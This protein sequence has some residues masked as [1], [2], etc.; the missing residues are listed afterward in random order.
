MARAGQR[1]QD[2]L[3]NLRETIRVV[4]RTL[5]LRVESGGFDGGL[6][7]GVLHGAL[8]FLCKKLKVISDE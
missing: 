5:M 8:R 2:G 6:C 7:G 1:V 4:Q 3:W